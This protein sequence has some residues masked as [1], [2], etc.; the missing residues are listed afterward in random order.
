F[1]SS[2][3]IQGIFHI[4]INNQLLFKLALSLIDLKDMPVSPIHMRSM[5]ILVSIIFILSLTLYLSIH[6]FSAIWSILSQF[7]Y[8]CITDIMFVGFELLV[9]YFHI[10][11]ISS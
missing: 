1:V 6:I 8:H 11:T 10:D 9:R 2:L 4:S 7:I 3:F 5:F